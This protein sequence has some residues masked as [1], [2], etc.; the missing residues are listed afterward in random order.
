[1]EEMNLKIKSKVTNVKFYIGD[2][3]FK[4]ISNLLD[5]HK[6]DEIL[7]LSN[8][9][10]WNLWSKKIEVSLATKRVKAIVLIPDGERYKNIN[11]VSNIY[12]SLANHGATRKTAL[13]AVGGGVIGDLGGFV[14]STYHRGIPLIHV[15]TTLLSQVDSSV[16]G[17]T[18]YNLVAGKNLV[19][20]FYQP[21]FTLIDIGFLDTLPER[22][23]LS[24]LSEII[25]A[26]LIRDKKLV[27]FMIRNRDK[28]LN[29]DSIS[30]Y[31]I[32]SKAVQIKINVVAKDEK[33]SGERAILNFGHTLAHAVERYKNWKILHGD[34]VAVGICFAAKISKLKGYI[35]E[36]KC[37]KIIDLI[38]SYKLPTKMSLSYEKLSSLI[39]HDKK[40]KDKDVEW[41][42]L[43]DI[44][45]AIW[46]EKVDDFV[47]R[48]LTR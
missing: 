41:V 14:A 40:R 20:T 1:M 21:L 36:L 2:K 26:G 8:D 47:I 30:L 4:N 27:N 28:I 22:E 17:K 5:K 45:D 31:H 10:V 32:I 3:I 6:V 7:I 15:P 38:K 19:G 13:L 24:G 18:G 37:K 12:N 42:L 9:T 29:K 46:G 11:T 35:D 16:G 34:A 44:G 23:Y 43:K 33:E 48:Q 25:K 39:N